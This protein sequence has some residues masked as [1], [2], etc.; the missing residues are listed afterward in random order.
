MCPCAVFL[1]TALVVGAGG[2]GMYAAIEAVRRGAN[3]LLLDRGLIGRDGATVMARITVAV[4]ARITVAVM[5]R[6]TV[7]VMARITVAAAV[8]PEATDHGHKR[9]PRP[10]PPPRPFR[11]APCHLNELAA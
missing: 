4:M 1:P 5:A 2:G 9:P 3:T 6:I 8:G 7:A 11:P 10:T